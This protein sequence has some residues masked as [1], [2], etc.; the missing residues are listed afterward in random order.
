V[1]SVAGGTPLGRQF[2]VRL[3]QAVTSYR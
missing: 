1:L 2:L 3:D